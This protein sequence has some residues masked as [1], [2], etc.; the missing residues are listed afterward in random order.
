MVI[1]VKPF[2]SSRQAQS[3]LC[4]KLRN[5]AA[6][7]IS[8]ALAISGAQA[9]SGTWTQITA[10]DASGTWSDADTVNWAGG[11]VASGDNFTAD[12]S[13][14][15]ITAAS[16]ITLGEP[17]TIGNL[18][19]GDTDNTT[20]A[21]WIL[22]GAGANTLTL[23]GTAPTIT[24]NDLGT[25][26]LTNSTVTISTSISGSNGLIK[27][28]TGTVASSSTFGRGVLVLSGSNNYTGGTTIS[29]GALAAANSSAFGAGDV[30]VASG[31]QL[32]V[33]GV[34]I[35]NT[36]NI[37]GASALF[38]TASGGSNLS[39]VVNL[40]SNSGISLATNSGNAT[41]TLSG[42]VNLN[43]NIL[44][45]NTIN[46]S[47][48]AVTIS[49]VV[50]GSGGI[51]KNNDG[52]LRIN[53]DNSL[54]YSGT[55]TL[56]RGVL[57]VGSDGAL[58]SG[59][60]AFNPGN[61]AA[62]TI[63]TQTST[64][65]TIAASVTL[66]G[67]NS[68]SRYIFGSTNPTFNGDLTFTSTN[69]IS[70]SAGQKRFEVGNRT[71]FDAGFAGTGGIT[72]QTTG[73]TGLGT[74]VL[75]GSN[76]Y[77]GATSVN[78]GTLLVNGSLDTGSVVT[79]G[80]AGTLGG[81]G[82]IGGNTTI[83]GILAPGSSTESLAFGGD[84][85]LLGTANTIMEITGTNRGVSVDGYDAVDLTNGAGLLTYD[86]TLTLTMTGLIAN[87]SY[88]LF[89]FTAPAAGS[90]DSIAFAGGGYTGAF[91]FSGV[92]NAWTATSDQGQVFTFDQDTGNLTVVPE[93]AVSMLVGAGLMTVLFR[94]R[95]Q[96][97][98]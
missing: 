36:V 76:T 8:T 47:T 62:A 55:T 65:R 48:P 86:G 64:A 29:S 22:A 41:M 17:R 61:D 15:N 24:V 94:R 9:A 25:G 23:S 13:T 16:T 34:N 6:L 95:R 81:G 77:T 3:V 90:F 33:R 93:P 26:S 56:A 4:S 75:N 68:A 54:T 14:L 91:V 46:V 92:D 83:S 19:F 82:A 79:V 20:V 37:N 58:G 27:D 40:Q 87:G 53:G 69:V 21:R 10:G 11:T 74:L 63:R 57:E 98:A 80:A 73:S 49:G 45:V 44:T 18:I 52:I 51:T 42:T 85:L 30:T 84:L 1:N 78:A 67:G 60:F 7:S 32:Q 43:G 89:A 35:A 39:G 5:V 70:L 28:G 50:S 66:G 38:S 31:A 71:Q 96:G 59:E 2:P 12:F 97:R 88:D 72:M